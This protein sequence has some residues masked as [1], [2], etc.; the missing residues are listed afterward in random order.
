MDSE[1]RPGPT[2]RVAV[3]PDRRYAAPGGAVLLA[4]LFLPEGVDVPVPVV[5]WIHGGGW[6]F[7]NRH[8]APDLTRFFARRGFGMVAIDYRLSTQAR[9]PAQIED[10]KT[11]IRW[12]RSVAPAY[13]LDASRVGLL[14]SS[15][16]GHLA[17][18][19]GLTHRGAFEPPDGPYADQP[20]SVQA[21][22]DAY[23]P[24]DFLQIDS[25][26]LPDDTRSDD[27]ETLLL[28]PGVTRSAQPDSFE[29]LLLGAPI[30]T[31]PDRVREANPVSY[32]GPGAPPVLILHGTSDT[33]VPAHQSE[34]L[35][36]ALAA[37]DNDVTL[38][39]IDGLGHGFLNRTH[40]DDG[41]PR[42][43]MVKR[44]VP[45]GGTHVEMRRQPIFGMIETFFRTRLAAPEP[46]QNAAA[47][48]DGL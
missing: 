33:T 37:Y 30:E 17:A 15:A 25:H 21:V 29:S 16:G 4:D 13:S 11:A 41:P 20:S 2:C 23:G 19:A 28:P 40:L 35:Y 6:R 44:H 47:S 38:A 26:R 46:I 14:G 48:P 18:L 24:T 7:G 42:Q 22:V 5:I 3:V 10:V 34:L 39:V 8:L 36:D 12:V 45:G 31:C 43:V 32:A 27:P 9:F 1:S